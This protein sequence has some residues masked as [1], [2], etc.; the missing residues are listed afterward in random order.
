VLCARE[1]SKGALKQ[2]NAKRKH[3]YTAER[4]LCDSN[5]LPVFDKSIIFT[6]SSEASLLAFKFY[7]TNFV[8]I[9][10]D[11]VIRQFLKDCQT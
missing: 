9:H 1:I 5:Q 3:F 10:I 2:T 6:L 7:K 4:H 11:S 8:Y